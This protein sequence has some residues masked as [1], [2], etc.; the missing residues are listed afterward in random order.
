M[1]PLPGEEERRERIERNWLIVGCV[2][3]VAVLTLIYFMH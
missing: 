2:I 1:I 3:G